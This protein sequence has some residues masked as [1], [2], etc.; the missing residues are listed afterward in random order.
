MFWIGSNVNWFYLLT[1]N[2]NQSQAMYCGPCFTS[3]DYKFCL[4]LLRQLALNSKALR[5]HSAI[6][7][8]PTASTA[9]ASPF[10]SCFMLLKLQTQT[11]CQSG[12]VRRIN[13]L[14]C[15]LVAFANFQFVQLH[16]AVPSC[17]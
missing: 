13:R 6:G 12:F 3:G 5:Y 4:R 16:C 7:K 1:P 17:P 15:M 8:W 11:Y 2:S 10:A 14:A 9:A